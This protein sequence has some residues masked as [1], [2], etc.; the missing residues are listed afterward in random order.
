MRALWGST[1][2]S[3]S[4]FQGCGDRQRLDTGSGRRS[5][6]KRFSARKAKLLVRICHGF[7]ARDISDEDQNQQKPLGVTAAAE[8]IKG[9]RASSITRLPQSTVGRRE[10]RA[11]WW[12]PWKIET[13]K[14]WLRPG[15]DRT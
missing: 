2:F 13:K 12:P 8:K 11:T 10:C 6:R 9:R 14:R 4:N 7:C 3:Q 5:H 1:G 15:L